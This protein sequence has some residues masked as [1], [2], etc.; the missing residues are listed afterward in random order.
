M[1]S[2]QQI[3]E[4]YSLFVGAHRQSNIGFYETV[5]GKDAWYMIGY[6]CEIINVCDDPEKAMLT[7][8][9]EDFCI[10]F[11][12]FKQDDEEQRQ[13]AAIVEKK[14]NRKILP[15]KAINMGICQMYFNHKNDE[16]ELI[17]LFLT[18]TTYYGHALCINKRTSKQWLS[19]C[20]VNETYLNMA[21]ELGYTDRIYCI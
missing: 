3:D 11:C 12:A 5:R 16:A 6:N 4:Y 18:S 2:Q 1:L 13:V 14:T 20:D 15:K 21:D 7:Q 17:F 19:G 10:A 8:D 9:I